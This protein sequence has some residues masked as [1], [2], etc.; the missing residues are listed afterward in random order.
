MFECESAHHSNA[1]IR[2]IIRSYFGDESAMDG[3]PLVL[4]SS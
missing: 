3:E 4:L 2:G 1:R